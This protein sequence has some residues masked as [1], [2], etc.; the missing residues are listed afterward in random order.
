MALLGALPE[1]AAKPPAPE[2]LDS[3]AADAAPW[4][5]TAVFGTPQELAALLDRGLDPNSKT[6]SGTTLLMMAVPDAEKSI[7]ATPRR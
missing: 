4:V 7:S 2:L 1:A 5:R 3:G 6:R